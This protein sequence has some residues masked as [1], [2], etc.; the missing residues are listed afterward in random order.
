MSDVRGKGLSAQSERVS[1]GARRRLTRR[2]IAGVGV[3]ADEDV[4][5]DLLGVLLFHLVAAGD[6]EEGLA[7]FRAGGEDEAQLGEL[8]GAPAMLEGVKVA[9]G[10]A[11][12]GAAAAAAPAC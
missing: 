8:A 7:D 5:G 9:S 12:A 3:E 1:E 4:R 6:V 11:G 2:D 10:C